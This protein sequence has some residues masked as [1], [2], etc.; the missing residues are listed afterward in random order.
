M[1][2]MKFYIDT[3]DVR[4]KTFPGGIS[5]ADFAG[6]Y[7]KYEEACRAEGVVSLRIHVGFEEGRAFCFNMAPSADAV[8]RVHDRVGL[9][10]EEITEVV[11]STPGD[12]F[13]A[14]AG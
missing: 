10:Y 5:K 1:Q 7:Q 9:P 14:K 8:K 12:L 4:T 3:H 2:K 11:T 13:F 6:F